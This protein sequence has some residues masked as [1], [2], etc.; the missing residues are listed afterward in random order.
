MW[1]NPVTYCGLDISPSAIE[2]ARTRFPDDTFHVCSE[3]EFADI[4]SR[5]GH[6]DVLI[7]SAVLYYLPVN[8]VQE[9]LCA[10]AGLADYI[11]IC[12]NLSAFEAETGRF[13]GIF[14]HQYARMCYL[15]GLTI[16]V[17]PTPLRQGDM[18]SYFIASAK[19][20]VDAL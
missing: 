19:A 9:L 8:K 13:D 5:L 15:A 14:L 1:P 16:V 11:L 4:T 10:A 12:D 7:A 18:H 3:Y 20:P 17:P 6:F 2:F